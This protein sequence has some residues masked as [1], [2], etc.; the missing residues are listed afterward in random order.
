MR[1]VLALG[2]LFL[3]QGLASAAPRII[4]I[5]PKV[6]WS[7]WE[8]WGC[9]L[10]WWA[11]VFSNRDDLADALY[12]RRTVPLGNM[13]LPGLGFN[14]VRYNAG[15]CSNSAFQGAKMVVSRTIEPYRQISGYWINGDSADPSSPS[16]DW[17]VDA[18]QRD[19]MLKAKIRG[20]D[21][22]ELFSNSPLWWML[23]NHNPSGSD[24]GKTET[25]PA[26][27]RRLHAIYLATIAQHAEEHW[28][29][30]FTTV[31]AFN[32]PASAWW[33]ANGTQE[34]AHFSPASQAS[35]ITFLRNA[36]DRRGLQDIAI[37][38]SDDNTYDE[39]LANWRE[40]PAEAQKDVGQINVHGYEG[41]KG[42]RGGLD[43][44]ARSAGKRLW[45]SE[46]GDGDATGLKMAQNLDLDLHQLHPTA[47]CYWQAVDNR[48]WG[49]FKSKFNSE[50]LGMA[51]P[52]YFVLAQYSR[53]IRP[54]MTILESTTG[55]V[56]AYDAKAHKLVLV[57]VNPGS[58]QTVTY[59]LSGFSSV[60]GPVA[61]WSTEPLGSARYR[62]LIPPA[63]NGRLLTISLP[64]HSV[65]TLEV[66]NLSFPSP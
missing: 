51:N 42:N 21:R 56:A 28:G 14:I 8:G 66:E 59:I 1:V 61:A 13:N 48:R 31:E 62:T 4:S 44:A 40:L 25:L 2:A 17:S 6:S 3:A 38:A 15:A 23:T 37:S 47:W 41:P 63:L 19:M 55:T 64:S 60:G 9:S 18:N 57:T 58:A 43:A 53:H 52:K 16:W 24:D 7:R 30:Q 27:N 54:G 5:N 26:E 32:E 49:L 29:V 50:G 11:N 35:I 39:A 36:L 10:C 45:N 46:Y 33:K 34:G 65:E 12:T 22:F 20:A